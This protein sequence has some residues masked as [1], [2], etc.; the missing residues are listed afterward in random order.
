MWRLWTAHYKKYRSILMTDSIH[1]S[2]PGSNGGAI[3]TTLHVNASSRTAFA[4]LFNAQPHNVTKP[5]RLP[6]YYAGLARGARVALTW[7]G[8]LV[9]ET[10]A[11][12]STDK[13]SPLN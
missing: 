5:L 4:N 8:S 11:P 13:R 7:G 12:K 1:V 2:R 6:V 10:V 9:S 3:E